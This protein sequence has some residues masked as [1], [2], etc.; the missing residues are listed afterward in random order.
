MVGFLSNVVY[1]YALYISNVL[2]N[3]VPSPMLLSMGSSVVDWENGLVSNRLDI[4]RREL[5]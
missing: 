2:A 5:Q 1:L 3:N 4:Q